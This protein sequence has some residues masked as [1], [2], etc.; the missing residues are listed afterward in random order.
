MGNQAELNR[1]MS[2]PRIIKVEELKKHSTEKDLW[3]LIGGKVFDVTEY[4][5]EHPG[6]DSIL[7]DIKGRDATCEFEDVGHSKDAI[8]TR[9]DLYI[10]DFDM[11]TIDELEGGNSLLKAPNAGGG[12]GLMAKAIIMLV[13][14]LVIAYVYK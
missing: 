2:Q 3:L 5:D 14:G 12:D 9:D 13:I 7:H 6:S 10:G 1:I 4:Q 11:E 8:K